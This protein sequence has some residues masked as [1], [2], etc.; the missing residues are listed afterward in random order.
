MC[1]FLCKETDNFKE[2]AEVLCTAFTFVVSF[3]LTTCAARSLRVLYQG[4]VKVVATAVSLL[5]KHEECCEISEVL[6][7]VL[8]KIQDMWDCYTMLTFLNPSCLHLQGQA[9]PLLAVLNCLT[10]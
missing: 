3:L 4:T 1:I 5:Y 7:L 9:V 8:L 10:T 6:R 2:M